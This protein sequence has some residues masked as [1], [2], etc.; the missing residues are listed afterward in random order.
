MAQ[1]A[2][3][4][5]DVVILAGGQGT[6]MGGKD[7]ALITI[8]GKRFLDRLLEDLAGIKEVHQIVVVSSRPLPLYPTITLVSE[9]P[10]F[11]GPLAAFH[12]GVVALSDHAAATTV[13]LAVDAPQS[14]RL[15]PKLLTALSAAPHAQVA[16]ISSPS[17][18]LE[19]L[20]TA[21]RT[22][23]LWEIFDQL[24]TAHAPLKALWP[25]RNEIIIIQ[26]T[27]QEKDYDTPSD[28][29][30]FPDEDHQME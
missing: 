28:L 20:C 17:G 21:W 15:I 10:P 22:D 24:E 29:A 12:A 30:E 3:P 13:V 7:K 6:R 16:A 1:I 5:V 4:G 19:P 2:H 26:G 27:G 23:K 11:S 18:H 25:A 14:A 8:N 9:T